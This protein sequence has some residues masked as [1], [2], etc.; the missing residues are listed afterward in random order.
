MN[1]SPLRQAAGLLAQITNPDDIAEIL[2]EMFDTLAPIL[3]ETLVA[4]LTRLLQYYVNG[5]E[6]E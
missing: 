3:I 5:D 1:P 2:Q 6:P 4:Q